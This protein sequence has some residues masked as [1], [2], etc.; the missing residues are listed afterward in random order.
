MS[1][2]IS[3]LKSD[4]KYFTPMSGPPPANDKPKAAAMKLDAEPTTTAK[5][6]VPQ[7]TNPG[8]SS[9]SIDMSQWPTPLL[10]KNAQALRLQMLKDPKAAAADK[11]LLSRIE[12]ELSNRY[13][14][15]NSPAPTSGSTAKV[16]LC[17][18]PADLPGN[19][20]VGLTHWWLKTP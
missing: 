1:E 16:E 8:L 3:S 12:H 2:P 13:A 10:E 6:T 18:R 15:A 11:D 17:E 4:P 9:A 5:V 19:S 14:V 7:P 20:K